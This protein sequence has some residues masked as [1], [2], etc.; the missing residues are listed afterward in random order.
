MQQALAGERQPV[1]VTGDA[2]I[3]KTRL[4][5]EVLRRADSSGAL[6]LAVGCLPLVD[7][8]PLLPVT[9]ALRQL[10][11]HAQGQVLRTALEALPSYVRTEV[12]R[13]LPRYGDATTGPGDPDA[14]RDRLFSAVVELLLHVGERTPVLLLTEDVHWADRE[15]LDMLTYLRA[16]TGD[17]RLRLLVTC[18]S[19]E[20]P[21]GGPVADWL[22]HVRGAGAVEIALAPLSRGD[23]AEQVTALTGRPVAGPVVDDLYARAEGNPFLTEQLLAAAGDSPAATPCLP[24]G[25]AALL[26]S[27]VRHV[28]PEARAVLAGLAVAGRPLIES[29]LSEITALPAPVVRAALRQLA[30]AA[31][32]APPGADGRS[33]PRHALL[34]EAVLTDLLPGERISLHAE[35]ARTL[36]ACEEPVVAAEV[37]GH[38]AAAGRPAD[39]LRA[40]VAAAHAAEGVFAFVDAAALWTRALDLAGQLPEVVGELGLDLA[41]LHLSTVDALAAAGSTVEAGT[42]A[43][44]VRER[45]DAWPDRHVA[46][47]LH[48]RA[49]QFRQF[50][51]AELARPLY[52]RALALFDGMPPSAEHAET[53][54]S[55]AIMWR[56]AGGTE[57]SA[58]LLERGLEVAVAAGAD[59]PRVRILAELTRVRAVRGEPTGDLRAQ[60]RAAAETVDPRVD[61]E[62]VLR[63]AA[64]ESDRALMAGELVEARRVGL[65]GYEQARRGGRSRTFS[66]SVLLAHAAEA[67][68]EL[69]ATG[70]AGR[71]LDPVTDGPPQ[72]GDFPL[73]FQRAALDVCRG[74]ADEAVR[75]LDAVLAIRVGGHVELARE[76]VQRLAAAHLWRRHP[77]AACA[78]VHDIVPR[79]AGIEQTLFAGELLVL[80]MRAAAD[81]AHSGV[82]RRDA[83]RAARARAAAAELT[84]AVDRMDVR[85]FRDHP[86]VVRIP[87]DRTEWTAE[88]SRLEGSSDAGAWE[89]VATRW[90]ELGRPHRAAYASWRCAEARLAKGGRC[91]DAEDPLRR[92]AAGAEEMLPL[93]AEIRRLAARARIPLEGLSPRT[94]PG[95]SFGLTERE[96]LV[97]RL[98]AEGRTNAQIGAD[99]YM[100]PKT[101]SVHVTH[102]LRKLGATNRTEAATVAERSGLLDEVDAR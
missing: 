68:L 63:A 29:A 28:G 42:L 40:S 62:P 30:D 91:A 9:D 100:S 80:G 15:T 14:G 5:T 53:L 81:L 50:D 92:A 99:L 88:R 72:A 65:T 31:L 98:V 39:E 78:A 64:T 60:L 17:T 89:E 33:R 16:T 41:R 79:L 82:V 86:H 71:V 45:F 77:E 36:E 32:L 43:E 83:R 55:Y 57:L 95:A 54:L 8:L 18:R 87:A 10:D 13:L 51:R 76:A 66:A 21:L 23:V 4:V 49:A 96:R 75:R 19:D 3:G 47:L 85:P 20:V 48:V 44:S 84:A 102:I 35:V 12:G 56:F 61:V 52:D 97:L 34:A 94:E 7:K 2:G 90:E 74:R 70:E 1:L 101:A 38:W 24:G 25:L 37:A 59:G 26:V 67:A 27:R 22:A 46:A 58:S 11:R 69:G 73:H 6:P 93:Q